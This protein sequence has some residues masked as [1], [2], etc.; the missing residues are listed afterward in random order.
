MLLRCKNPLVSIGGIVSKRN[1]PWLANGVGTF[2][3]EM[4]IRMTSWDN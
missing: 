2:H 1:V 4:K 3:L